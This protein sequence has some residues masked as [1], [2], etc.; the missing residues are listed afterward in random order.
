MKIAVKEVGKPLEITETTEKYRTNCAKKVIGLGKY[1]TVEF[2]RL[3]EDGTLA[4]CVDEDGLPKGLP[5]NFLM[6]F[7]SVHFPI[8]KIV[9]KVAFC[10][11][12]YVNVFEEEI[13]D[14]E[15]EDLT[16]KDIAFINHLL[17]EDVQAKLKQSFS[18][19]DKGKVIFEPFTGF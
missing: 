10:R 2:V 8:Q 19:Y 13:W 16:D 3:N 9:G 6:A 7:K 12:K 18:D 5:T 4:L 11:V 17:S 15:V 14:Y 1:D